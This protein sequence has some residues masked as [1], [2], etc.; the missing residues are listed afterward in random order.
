MANLEEHTMLLVAPSITAIVT[1]HARHEFLD[2]AI[3][4]FFGRS[5]RRFLHGHGDGHA[6]QFMDE[7]VLLFFTTVDDRRVP[8]NILGM[9]AN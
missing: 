6:R 1:D 3:L 2:E 9:R 5:G 8:I 7:D 4:L